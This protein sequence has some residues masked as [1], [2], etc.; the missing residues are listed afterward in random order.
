MRS[1]QYLYTHIL[2]TRLSKPTKAGIGFGMW[3]GKSP[4]IESRCAKLSEESNP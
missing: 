3:V 1:A 2:N 4:Q